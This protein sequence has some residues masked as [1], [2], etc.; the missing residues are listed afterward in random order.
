MITKASN[1]QIFTIVSIELYGGGIGLS[2]SS[3]HGPPLGFLSRF[4]LRREVGG[5]H[6]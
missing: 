2:V 5:F 6:F 4:A 1:Q 3:S